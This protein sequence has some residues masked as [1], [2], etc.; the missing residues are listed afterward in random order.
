M[1]RDLL[2]PPWCASQRFTLSEAKICCSLTLIWWCRCDSGISWMLRVKCF[3]PWIVSVF[4]SI[5]VMVCLARLKHRIQNEKSVSLFTMLVQIV[6]YTKASWSAEFKSPVY[7][8]LMEGWSPKRNLLTPPSNKD[9]LGTLL[10]HPWLDNTQP[11]TKDQ[12][13]A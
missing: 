8:N 5:Y 1:K 3:R 7:Q 12:V 9:S 4:K 13:P 10:G 6:L 2:D 11:M